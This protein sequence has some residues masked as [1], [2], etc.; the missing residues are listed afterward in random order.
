M[1]IVF[2]CVYVWDLEHR[3]RT[4]GDIWQRAC[5]EFIRGMGIIKGVSGLSEVNWKGKVQGRKR[6]DCCSKDQNVKKENCGT[7]CASQD[8]EIIHNQACVCRDVAS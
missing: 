7:E 3:V 6:T 8:N 2:F 5:H 4:T 1:D